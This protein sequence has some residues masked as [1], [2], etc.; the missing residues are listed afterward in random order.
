MYLE[1]TASP[2]ILRKLE[3]L[4]QLGRGILPA[5]D[6]IADQLAASSATSNKKLDDLGQ[7]VGKIM[8]TEQQ[9]SDA[10]DKIDQATTDIATNVAAISTVDATISTE[11]T[12]LVAALQAAGVS[13]ALVD[14]ATA[15]QAKAQAAAT[16]LDAQI[17]VLQAIASQG[18]L[19]PVPTPVPVPPAPPAPEAS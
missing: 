15:L 10:L 13:Q 19:N 4:E 18:V 9:V 2:E 3:A 1:G 5:L 7:K 8:A 16:A 17:P 14:K 12:A 6:G 11:M